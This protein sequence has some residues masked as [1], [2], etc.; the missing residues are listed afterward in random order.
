MISLIN[1]WVPEGLYQRLVEKK[2]KRPFYSPALNRLVERCMS[3]DSSMRPKASE[4]YKIACHF[5]D[6][7]YAKLN[8]REVHARSHD[9]SVYLG[10]VLFSRADQIK[11]DKHWNHRDKTFWGFAKDYREVNFGPLRDWLGITR[12]KW[13]EL[14]PDDQA[15]A[16][17]AEYADRFLIPLEKKENDEVENTRLILQDE[18]HQRW[19]RDYYAAAGHLVPPRPR[20]EFLPTPT[21]ATMKIMNATFQ[22]APVPRQNS[23]DEANIYFHETRYSTSL[24]SW[25]TADFLREE[26]KTG[27]DDFYNGGTG[28]YSSGGSE[29]GGLGPRGPGGRGPGGRS[30]GGG[31]PDG[32]GPGGGGYNTGSNNHGGHRS[33]SNNL[34][35][36]SGNSDDGTSKPVQKAGKVYDPN[37]SNEAFEPGSGAP[38]TTRFAA[39]VQAHILQQVDELGD[40]LGAKWQANPRNDTYLR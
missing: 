24:R 23:I 4:I 5:H 10:Q 20:P 36:G 27:S 21:S 8:S 30:P 34:S 18:E 35:T 26:Y 33:H 16:E 37:N 1:K 39:N 3:M 31:D 32:R 9:S 19:V 14:D 28:D 12:Q 6:V 13:R 11:Y 29:G 15:P 22:D 40:E 17:G 7:H 25:K 38:P 2:L